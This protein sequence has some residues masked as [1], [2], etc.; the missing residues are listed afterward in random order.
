MKR[1][2]SYLVFS[3]AFLCLASSAYSQTVSGY[4]KG[5]KAFLRYVEKSL[6]LP[7]PD[8]VVTEKHLVALIF[9]SLGNIQSVRALTKMNNSLYTRVHNSFREMGGAWDRDKVKNQVLILPITYWTPLHHS[10]SPPKYW[11]QSFDHES[12]NEVF[13]YK[14]RKA[15]LFQQVVIIG[16]VQRKR[17]E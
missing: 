14:N 10:D 15:V 8:S 1:R 3:I 4:S 6:Q 16:S 7:W 5:D 2:K 12:W 13:T 9:D 17:V 11:P